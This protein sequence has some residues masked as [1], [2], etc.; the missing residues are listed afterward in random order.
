MFER[1]FRFVRRVAAED[2]ELCEGAQ[3]NLA[4]GVYSQGVLNVRRRRGRMGGEGDGEAGTEREGEEEEEEE[5]LGGKEN[6]VLREC[7]SF[8]LLFPG[9][10]GKGGSL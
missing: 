8:P 9:R 2:F 3:G 10:W 5:M 1:Y 4:R 7:F 6:G